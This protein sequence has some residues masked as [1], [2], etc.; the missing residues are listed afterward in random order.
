MYTKVMFATDKCRLINPLRWK[1]LHFRVEK[2][3]ASADMAAKGWRLRGLV[4]WCLGWETLWECKAELLNCGFPARPKR[5]LKGSISF[6][7]VAPHL[8]L[9]VKA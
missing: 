7:L 9:D 4:A 1:Y 3:W 5:E 6:S 8:K 2:D